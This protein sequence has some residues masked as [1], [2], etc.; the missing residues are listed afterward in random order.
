MSGARYAG[1]GARTCLIELAG[2]RQVSR[3]LE[4]HTEEQTHA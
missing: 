3:E 2:N 4:H 1:A